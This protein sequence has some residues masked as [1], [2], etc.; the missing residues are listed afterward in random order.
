MTIVYSRFRVSSLSAKEISMF[1]AWKPLDMTHSCFRDFN[2]Y[3]R[4]DRE[5]FDA[6]AAY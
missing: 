3:D 4:L 2:I 1:L 6:L 5:E